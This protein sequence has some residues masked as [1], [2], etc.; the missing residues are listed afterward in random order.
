MGNRNTVVIVIAA[1]FVG[2]MV[3]LLGPKL[4]GTR[5]KGT[6]VV[7][8]Q[9]PVPIPAAEN[10]LKINEL[11]RLLER[12]PNDVGV[13]V[14]LG[15]TYFD[16]NMYQE[17]IEAY[18]RALALRPGNPNV[19]TD[20][21]VMYRR[22]GRSDEAIARFREAMAVDPNHYQSRMNLGI[23]LYYDLNDMDGAR[24]AFEDFLR[25]VP[26]GPQADQVRGML[27]RMP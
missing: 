17:S 18:E 5:P 23:V 6:T 4:F 14:Q 12:N 9:A 22:S 19:L 11:K 21:G 15:N 8:A 24:E 3:G 7:P 27:S 25:L 10:T 1:L 26:S 16:S 2:L 20:L 13:L